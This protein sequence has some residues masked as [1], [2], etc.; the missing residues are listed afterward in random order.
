MEINGKDYNVLK[1]EKSQNY[2]MRSRP[3]TPLLAPPPLTKKS[4]CIEFK[5]IMLYTGSS[6]TYF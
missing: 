4:A 3:N 2:P 5:C 1:E 6:D